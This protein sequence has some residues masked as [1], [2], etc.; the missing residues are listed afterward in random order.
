MQNKTANE[1]LRR[2]KTNIVRTEDAKVS[3]FLVSNLIS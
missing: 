2:L 3:F 1:M